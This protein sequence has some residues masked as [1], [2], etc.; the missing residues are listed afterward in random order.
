MERLEMQELV[1]WKEKKDRKPLLLK[2]ARQVGKTWL[3]KEFGKRY[4][5]NVVYINFDRDEVMKKVF[6]QDFDIERILLALNAATK[7][8]IV[9]QKTLLIFDEIQEA[10]RAISALKYFCEDAK[11]YAV[12][13]AGS[14]LGVAIHKGVSFPVGKVDTLRL[15]PLN[16][17]EFL[18]ATGENGLADFVKQ[19]NYALM[20]DFHE[21][22]VELL[23]TYYYVGGMPEAVNTF[24][25]E[26]DYVQVRQVQKNILD[27]YEADLGKHIEGS[28]LP[29]TRLV[30]NSIPMQLA[31]E[32]KKFFFGQI[33]EGARAR[34]FELSIEWLLDCG[35]IYKVYR[36][37]KPALPLK[38]Y[39][40]FAAFKLYFLDIGLLGAMSDLDAK[41]IIDGNH[42]FTEFKGALTEQYVL[43]ELLSE[44]DMTPYYFAN[45]SRSEIDFLLQ[46]DGNVV[47]I[48]VKAETNIR[49]RSLA[50][51]CD[52]YEPTYAVRLSML[53]YK[54]Q[55][56][57]VN[58]SLYAIGVLSDCKF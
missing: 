53:P 54:E 36:V 46:I 28:E 25:Q 27:I 34:E 35:L 57:L 24:V 50:A 38:A 58:L 44:T 17:R 26:K 19:K 31:K 47:P 56:R 12:I 32:N 42:I 55:D 33:K 15:M 14:L 2:G 41:T 16:F 23:K 51:Y 8:K 4:F 13:A 21:K 52:K 10:P 6:E 1:K 39:T 11:E 22:Y 29:R 9:P 45:S 49:A 43:Q 40:D 18:L 3:M 30:W 20:G 37:E 7:E 5:E 48:E